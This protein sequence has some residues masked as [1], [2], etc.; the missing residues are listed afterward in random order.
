VGLLVEFTLEV[1]WVDLL[2]ELMVQ[3]VIFRRQFELSSRN[4]KVDIR[5]GVFL[6]DRDLNN[7]F[8]CLFRNHRFDVLRLFFHHHDHR[9]LFF[10]RLLI[11]VSREGIETFRLLFLLIQKPWLHRPWHSQIFD[12]TVIFGRGLCGFGD[13][14]DAEVILHFL[15][16][17]FGCFHC[18]S[19]RLHKCHLPH[20]HRDEE[21]GQLS[22]VHSLLRILILLPLTQFQRLLMHNEPLSC[23]QVRHKLLHKVVEHRLEGFG[24][25][26]HQRD[27]ASIDVAVVGPNLTAAHACAFLRAVEHDRDDHPFFVVQG[28][29]KVPTI[30][31]QRG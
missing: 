24:L 30:L 3:L 1:L 2:L 27:N 6:L 19:A 26:F 13:I 17:L 28:V 8:S 31:V 9:L 18:F 12:S 11:L 20:V 14:A 7:Q 25:L 15:G 21:I 4:V 16:L 29:S 23:L 10:E 5:S 22:Q